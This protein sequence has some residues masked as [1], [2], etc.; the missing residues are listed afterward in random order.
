MS[1][2]KVV[3]IVGT[4]T[5]SWED[6]AVTALNLAQTTLRDL[7]VAEVVEQDIDLGGDELTFRTKLRVSFKYESD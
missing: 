2:Y 3:E 6:A 1:V 5:S 4:S 7:R